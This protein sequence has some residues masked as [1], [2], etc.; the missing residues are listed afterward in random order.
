MSL[1]TGKGLSQIGPRCQA[2]LLLDAVVIP[3][4]HPRP[5][6]TRSPFSAALLLLLAAGCTP[7]EPA[8]PRPLD[9]GPPPAPSGSA[10]AP[11]PPSDPLAVSVVPVRAPSGLVVDGNLSE[12]GAFPPAPPSLKRPPPDEDPLVAATAPAPPAP[13]PP[14]AASRVAFALTGDA[15][16]LAAD[17]GEAAKEGVWVGVG[18][19]VPDLP[20]LGEYFGR[21]GFVVLDC[22]SMPTAEG[23]GDDIGYRT[24]PRPPEMADAC[25]GLKARHAEAKAKHAARFEKLFRID[26][27]GVRVAGPGGA[28]SAIEGAKSVWKSGPHGATVEVSL[29]L[30]A[31]PR[32]AEAPL[33]TVRLAARISTSAPVIAT[34]QWV[35]LS[36][37]EPAA[38]EPH[39]DLRAHAIRRAEDMGG[40][41][42]GTTSYKQPR[43]VSYQPGDP[44][45]IEVYDSRMCDAATAHEM[46][47]FVKLGAI[48]DVEVG[49]A[50]APRGHMCWVE[51]EPWIAVLQKGKPA[52]LVQAE[53]TPRGAIVR[54]GEIHVLNYKEVGYSA[55]AGVWSVTAI[56]PSGAHREVVVDPVPGTKEADFVS[57]WQDSSEFLGKDS[58]TFGWRGTKGGKGLEATWTW[59]AAGKTYKG[60]QKSIPAST[61]KITPK[62]KKIAPKKSSPKK[63]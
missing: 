33:Q 49:R 20:L 14:N 26:R 4:F 35:W 18:A 38:F 3:L 60:T 13:N 17:L 42:P 5:T 58:D 25:R 39:A 27:D 15:A 51:A 53:G 55:V 31:M 46:P 9:V 57:Y 50:A 37:P 59:D 30:S 62:K 54:G 28:L 12:W 40:F 8:T 21:M 23:E 7:P 16:L 48:G 11:A 44:L 32:M 22:E 41:P 19:R 1:Q 47:L 24:D 10:E 29:P 52:A 6:M 34:E 56:S 2:L 61:K 45:H 63:K 43:G 36:L